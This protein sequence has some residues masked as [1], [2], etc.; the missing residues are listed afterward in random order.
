MKEYIEDLNTFAATRI[1]FAAPGM[2]V[3][4]RPEKSVA[5]FRVMQ[6]ALV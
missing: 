3:E 6:E 4:C 5:L 1:T 2:P